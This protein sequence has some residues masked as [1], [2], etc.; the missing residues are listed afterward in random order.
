MINKIQS[1]KA[2]FSTDGYPELRS[3]RISVCVKPD[4]RVLACGREEN[5]VFES[6][7]SPTAVESS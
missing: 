1:S 2:A 3:H 7:T 4:T 6:Q 5:S